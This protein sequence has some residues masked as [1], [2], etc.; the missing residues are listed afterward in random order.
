MGCGKSL[1]GRLLADELGFSFLDLDEALE[2]SE[3]R[4]ISEIFEKD[5]EEKFR[6]LETKYLRQTISLK[7]CVIATG[8]GLPCFHGNMDWINEQGLSIFLEV[9]PPILTKRL[10][11]ESG[12]RPLLAKLSS[13]ELELFIKQKLEA[14]TKF[15]HRAHFV[16]HAADQ[17]HMIVESLAKYFKRYLD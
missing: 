12:H 10:R 14:R 8:G 4:S 16:C 1:V 13:L 11:N 2:S 3:R 6:F 7:R 15:Y 9:P 5:G 17:P